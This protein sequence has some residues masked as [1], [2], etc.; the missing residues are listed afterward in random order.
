[1]PDED[2]LDLIREIRALDAE[3]GCRTPAAALT[4][5]ARAEDRTR[6]I[7]AGYQIHIPKPVDPLELASVVQRLARERGAA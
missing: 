7:G 6:S 4:G 1:M 3:S 2:G 5:L